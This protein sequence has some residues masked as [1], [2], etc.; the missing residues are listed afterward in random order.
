M[1]LV[2]GEVAVRV[3]AI[4]QRRPLPGAVRISLSM[5]LWATCSGDV[6]GGEID[7]YSLSSTGVPSGRR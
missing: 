2:Q 6:V 1:H 5:K 4:G 7:S 3:D